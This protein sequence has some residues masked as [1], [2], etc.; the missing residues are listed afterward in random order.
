[1]AGGGSGSTAAV[2]SF[3]R[4]AWEPVLAK[5]RRA[6]VFLDAACAESL[7]WGGG[8]AARLLAAGALR[9][10]ELS[11]F[12]AGGPGQP[13]ALFVVSGL[14]RGRTADT[15]HDVLSLSSFQYCV[16]FTA[17]SPAAHLLA[18][19]GGAEHDTGG[20]A[21]AFE[22]FE[23]KMCQWMGNLG[24]TAE[25]L[26][27]PLLLAPVSAHLFV[28]P[29]FSSLF[30]LMPEDLP[31]LNSSRPEKRKLSNLSD[32]DFALLPTELQLQIRMLVS[33]LN[34]LFEFLDVREESFAIGTL[35]KVIAGDL[36]NYAL[37]KNRRKTAQGRASVI[38]IDRTLDLTG[39]VGHHGDNL[40]EKVL[41]VLPKLPGHAN[42]VMVNMVE[43]TAL[44]TP[45]DSCSIIAPGCL[46]QPN[47]P[48]A[49]ALWESFMNL[50]HKEAV[51]EVRRHLV[52]AASRENLPIKMSMGRVTPEQLSSYIQLFKNNFKALENHCGLLQLV[53]ATIQTLKHPK[54]AKWDNFLAFERL[55]L[56]N[57]GES[58]MPSVLNQLLPM[59]KS[60]NNRK[61]DDYNCE[62]FLI[63]L[64][65]IYSVVGEVR[66]GKALDEAEGEVKKAL[67][68]AF[69]DEPELSSLLQKITGCDSAQTL[70]FEKAMAAVDSIFKSLWD[71]SRA[72]MHMKQFNSVHIPGSNIHQATY[73]PLLKQVVEEIFNSDRPDPVDIEHMSAGLTDLLKT[74]FSMFM[75]VNRPHPGDHPLLIFYMVGGVTVSEVKMLKDLISARKPSV[76]VIVLSSTLLTPLHIPE[77]LFAADH[78]QPDIGI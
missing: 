9:V 54:N 41:S 16:V 3:C 36:A 23:E 56:Q 43:L 5:A 53:L 76:Q 75:K 51:M 35:S 11:S 64:V 78:L 39:A 22:L 13:K 10:K 50:K 25:V 52:E 24:Y 20:A 4:Q 28:M 7:H 49:K 37:A 34:A 73:K 70:T 26:H 69:C 71:V 59:I 68:Q 2:L 65:Y 15:I 19:R 46:A 31:C 21:A 60:H 47:D 62:D 45:D 14:L 66:A 48:A 27:V 72:R 29:A 18:Q 44:Q 42:D 8:G 12:E 30:P 77:L 6:V 1:M 58:E 61:E 33:G 57:I 40:A 67:V 32:L 55:L 17:A 63:L 38:F 74:G